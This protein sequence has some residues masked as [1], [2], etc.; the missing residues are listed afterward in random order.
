MT[1]NVGCL[2]SMPSLHLFGNVFL[3]VP[4]YGSKSSLAVAL[5]LAIVLISPRS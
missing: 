2:R 5:I 3:L 1:S 4:V